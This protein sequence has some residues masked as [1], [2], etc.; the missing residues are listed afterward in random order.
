MPRRGVSPRR[1]DAWCHPGGVCRAR[2][3]VAGAAA[4]RAGGADALAVP[5]RP[6]P[7]HPFVG[8]PQAAI[9]DPGVRQP[10]GRLL[11]H[12]A[13]PFDRGGADRPLDR[14]RTGAGRGPDRGAGAGARPG[15]SAVRPRRGGGAQPGDE[16]VRR[17]RPQCA[18]PARG[19][20]AGEPLCRLGRAE[21]DL[22]DAGGPGQAQRPAAQPAGL[23]RRIQRS[24]P[25]G[26]F[27]PCQRRGAGR[28]AGGRCRLSQPRSGRRAARAA[29]RTGGD[30]PS[31]GGGRGAGGG[32]AVQPGRAAAAVAA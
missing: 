28:R 6:R 9:Q 30:R 8:V 7:H 4:S 23:H 32:A 13:D 19:D 22:G 24:A 25:A 12:A 31:A 10:R 21:P 15:P 29:V 16:A 5:A 2:R 14:P 26:A 3:L 11:P 17:L 1:H 18:E 20:A 27:H